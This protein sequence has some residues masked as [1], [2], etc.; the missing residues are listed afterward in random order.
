MHVPFGTKESSYLL[1]YCKPR[2]K[3]R[4][5]SIRT[6]Y[7]V[8]LMQPLGK[9]FPIYCGVMTWARMTENELFLLKTFSRNIPLSI[10]KSFSI[11]FPHM[12]MKKSNTNACTRLLFCTVKSNEDFL[13]P[14]QL[15]F[16]LFLR[17]G[18]EVLRFLQHVRY[19]SI[20]YKIS[21]ES[22]FN[23]DQSC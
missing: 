2:K 1:Q 13:R 8:T 11:V 18:I 17:W 4:N 15:H 14:L 5:T 3:E 12:F 21:K 22:A 10:W 6:L 20:H 23:Y 9:F 7:L 16:P 19:F